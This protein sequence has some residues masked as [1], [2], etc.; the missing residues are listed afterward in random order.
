MILRSRSG[1]IRNSSSGLR[2]EPQN[3]PSFGP[4]RTIIRSFAKWIRRLRSL[5][6][7]NSRSHSDSQFRERPTK[8]CYSRLSQLGITSVAVV[9]VVVVAPY[10]SPEVTIIDANAKL[11]REANQI[12]IENLNQDLSGQLFHFSAFI[13]LF[14]CLFICPFQSFVRSSGLFVCSFVR[15]FMRSRCAL[16]QFARQPNCRRRSN[17]LQMIPRWL[18]LN[19]TRRRRN[20]LWGGGSKAFAS[21]EWLMI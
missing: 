20:N 17:W 9:V 6:A 2:F 11:T 8:R 1:N 18:R 13:C 3:R 12:E 14:V 19:S 10:D 21:G 16:N 15:P 5:V 4:K 7:S